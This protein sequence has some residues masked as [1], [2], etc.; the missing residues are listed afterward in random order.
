MRRRLQRPVVRRL[1]RAI[2]AAA[3]VAFGIVAYVYLTLPDVRVLARTNPTTTAFMELRA[4]QARDEGRRLRKAHR[5]VTYSRI[6]P[7]L[8][9]AVI[10][11]EDGAFWQHEGLDYEEIRKSIEIAFEQGGELR[12]ASTITQQLAKNLY[13]SPSR[14]P[15]RKLRELIITRRLEA[16]LPKARI[17]ELYLN[18]VEW[19][20]GVWGA[21]AATRT[22]FGVSASA[23]SREQA[24]L[25]AGALINPIAYSPAR[26]PSR[27]LRRQRIILSRMGGVTP[28]VVTEVAPD[29]G[30]TSTDEPTVELAPPSAEVVSE[31]AEP[32]TGAEPG[33][34]H[35]DEPALPAPD[36]PPDTPGSAPV[37]PPE[38]RPAQ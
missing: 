21:E 27:L 13:L 28:P 30:M 20:D 15:L 35:P 8:K 6:S 33:A 3:A 25:L 31:D 36:V 11:A 34:A 14:N 23:L 32:E 22:Y 24:A 7:N 38:L 9:R 29:A 19:G 12:G 4:R 17:F 37:S 26:P 10:V 2:A 1:G 18:V 16:T 5:W